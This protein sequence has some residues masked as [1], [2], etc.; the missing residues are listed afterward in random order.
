MTRK[1][2]IVPVVLV[3]AAF[4]VVMI[5]TSA[6][7]AQTV[8]RTHNSGCRHSMPLNAGG[9]AYNNSVANQGALCPVETFTPGTGIRVDGWQNG[10]EKLKAKAC[11]TFNIGGGT[12]GACD[13][14]VKDSGGAKIVNLNVVPAVY[15]TFPN[16]Y[17]Y[18]DVFV[19][20]SGPGFCTFFGITH[21]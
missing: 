15:A 16:D 3:P 7:M 4:L 12:G 9:Q 13:P 14:E 11:V 5:S 20:T 10:S 8:V 6:A 19:G 17:K 21:S 18:V 1:K 2:S